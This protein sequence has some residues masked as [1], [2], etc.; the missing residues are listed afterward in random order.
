MNIPY[1]IHKITTSQ[2]AM[3]PENVAADSEI[4]VSANFNF[5]INTTLNSLR[6]VCKI[7]YLLKE[8]LVMV[9]EVQCFFDIAPEAVG[10]LKSE[11]R[12]PVDFLRYI[13]TIVIGTARGIIHTKTENTALNGF[14]L[15]PINLMAIIKQDMVIKD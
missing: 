12:I 14:V 5:G 3:F 13:G 8:D 15:P 2:F 11:K 4:E 6:C 1:R 10:N 9:L 7:N